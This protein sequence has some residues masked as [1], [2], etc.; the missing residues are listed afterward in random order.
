MSQLSSLEKRI[1]ALVHESVRGCVLEEARHA[2]FIGTRLA[3]AL[4]A[5]SVAPLCLAI[6]GAPPAWQSLAFTFAMMPLVAVVVVSRSGRIDVGHMVCI[7][8]LMGLSVTISLGA[9]AGSS[10]AMVWLVLAPLEAALSLS[11]GLIAGS[12][13]CALLIA[14]LMAAA[15]RY[16]II[17]PAGSEADLDLIFSSVAVLYALGL[18]GCWLRV[19]E[20]R[21]LSEVADA[22]RYATLSEA[23]GDLVLRFDRSGAVLS[24][25]KESA[26]LVGITGRDLMGRGFF[27]RIQVA[28]R[29]IFLRAIADAAA[30]GQTSVSTVRLRTSSVASELGSFEE[31]VFVWVEI[32][33]RQMILEA[34]AAEPDAAR[35]IAVVRNVSDRIEAQRILE[36][37]RIESERTQGWKDRFLANV[38]H[39]LRTPLNAIIGFS[40]MLGN[41]Q[42]A[43]RDEGKRREYAGIIH[44]SGQH[45]LS[46]VNSIL[47]MSKIDAGSFEVLAE[48]FPVAPLIESCCDMVR[49]KA[50][51]ANVQ[52][53]Q[54]CPASVDE[55]VADKRA[56]KQILLNLLSNAVKFTPPGGKVTIGVRPE[57]NSLSFYV[58][59]TGIGITPSDLPRLGDP[60]FQARSSYDRPYEGTGLGLSVVKG[61]VGLHGGTI[62]LES[63]PGKGTCVT[64]RL[65]LNCRRVGPPH[66]TAKIEVI[67]RATAS[68]APA[69]LTV[70]KIA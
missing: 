69:F 61:L 48:P 12:A 67:T 36:N 49:L 39:E 25:G 15:G 66:S 45:L 34:R 9:G 22:A 35:V 52:I 65:P 16:G 32:R 44:T 29:P 1:Q 55:L 6:N 47:D 56:C 11:S 5:A 46:V 28:D 63:E 38:S 53:L 64:V 24:T 43:P 42:L 33:A 54:I 40:E 19:S 60:F 26:T 4:I 23:L 10:A 50:E 27:E 21:R 14:V 17:D 8:G 13:I 68:T 59:D 51:E 18:A 70:K 7:I 2:M 58:S 37:S 41:D 20:M 57:G 3:L 30:G 31:P 62:S